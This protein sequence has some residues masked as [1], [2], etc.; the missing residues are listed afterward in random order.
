M[1]SLRPKKHQWCVNVQIEDIKRGLKQPGK[2]RGGLAK[3]LNVDVSQVSRLLNGKRQLKVNEVPLIQEYLYGDQDPGGVPPSSI[4]DVARFAQE[5]L[6][7]LE[8]I[9]DLLDEAER[10]GLNAPKTIADALREA[11]TARKTDAWLEKNKEAIESYNAFVRQNGMFS[12]RYRE[13]YGSI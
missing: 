3:C 13:A 12:T 6:I 11:I 5:R 1:H 8:I 10:C 4:E 2:T 7:N 9:S